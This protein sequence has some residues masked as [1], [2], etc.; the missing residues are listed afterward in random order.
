MY[1]ASAGVAITG[2]IMDGL[3]ADGAARQ[4]VAYGTLYGEFGAA[5]ATIGLFNYV[6]RD[7]T[8]RKLFIC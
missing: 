3:R 5:G 4:L 1:T 7:A 8:R 2:G 6:T